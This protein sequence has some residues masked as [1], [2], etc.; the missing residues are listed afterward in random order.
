M[1]SLANCDGGA[2]PARCAGDDW[3][4][5]GEDDA[6]A[7]AA[8]AFDLVVRGVASDCLAGVDD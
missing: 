3:K 5:N 2:G 7:A 1:P 4:N 6:T 8:F